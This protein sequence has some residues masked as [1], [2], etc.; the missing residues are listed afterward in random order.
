V[1]IPPVGCNSTFHVEDYSSFKW[2]LGFK[3]MPNINIIVI[4]NPHPEDIDV[5][6]NITT[7]NHIIIIIVNFIS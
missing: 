2:S 3:T 7:N 4:K 1:V 6:N 5:S